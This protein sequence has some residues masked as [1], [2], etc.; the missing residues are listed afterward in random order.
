[1]KKL[2]FK[3]VFIFVIVTAVAGFF[4]GDFL[5]KEND[6]MW[7]RYKEKPALVT[8]EHLDDGAQD[9]QENTKANAV[10][11]DKN[12]DVLR[13]ESMSVGEKL[14]A[15]SPNDNLTG[16]TTLPILN[17]VLGRPK[18]VKPHAN[19]CGV[20]DASIVEFNNIQFKKIRA[21]YYVYKITLAGT[22]VELK[23]P[24]LLLN[25]ETKLDEFKSIYSDKIAVMALD[26]PIVEEQETSDVSV[27]KDD[28]KKNK[29]DKSN[30]NKTKNAPST[31]LTFFVEGGDQG[32]WIVRFNNN[33]ALQSVEYDDASCKVETEKEETQ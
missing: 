6:Q 23:T 24:R 10:E 29:K 19:E 28:N 20:Q 31:D 9:V 12:P 27:E 18:S 5:S 7:E 1:M 17:E 15:F 13:I 33:G 8:A 4:I 25:K 30:K 14:I 21:E 2:F 22:K 16:A 3:I 32:K 26:N 11:D